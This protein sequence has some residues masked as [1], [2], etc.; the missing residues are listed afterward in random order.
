MLVL[1]EATSALDN[2]TESNLMNAIELIG[3]RCTIVLIA[4]RLS[5]VMKCD[6]IYEFDR[7]MIKASGTFQSL[8]S[9]SETFYE[10]TSSSGNNLDTI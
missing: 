1:D 5:T 7:G 4:H 6:Y 2:N 3:R 8:R 9:K 10:M